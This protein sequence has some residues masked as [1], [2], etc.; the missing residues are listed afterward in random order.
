ML[1]VDRKKK[2]GTMTQAGVALLFI[3]MALSGAG[4]PV[5]AQR[6]E[7]PDP[8]QSHTI[9]SNSQ[10]M[11]QIIQFY[12]AKKW[13]MGSV[14]VAR[15]NDMLLNR[16]YGLAN[17]EWDVP[18]SAEDEVSSRINYKAVHGGVD[19]AA[20]RAG[21]TERERSRQEIYARST[22][23]LGQGYEF[24]PTY[25]HLRNPKLHELSNIRVS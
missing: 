11:E 21:K 10:R 22:G 16:S 5:V 4:R 2:R 15:G 6:S 25:G 7:S 20:P 17:M 23:N 1:I 14:L 9:P 8:H 13:F 3:T 24:Q 18:D 12:V 19:S